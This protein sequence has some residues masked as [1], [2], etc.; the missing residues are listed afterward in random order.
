MNSTYF[1]PFCEFFNHNCVDVSYEC[2]VDEEPKQESLS[3]ASSISSGNSEDYIDVGDFDY[4][5][6]SSYH[7]NWCSKVCYDLKDK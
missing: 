2:I 1:T 7:I 3:E 5:E 4:M 6:I